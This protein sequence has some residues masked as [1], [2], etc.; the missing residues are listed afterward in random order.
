VDV[1]ILSLYFVYDRFNPSLTSLSHAY[2]DATE[3]QLVA[4]EMQT[5]HV[6]CKAELGWM[7]ER[8][9]V[10]TNA[11]ELERAVRDQAIQNHIRPWR[12]S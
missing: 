3:A 7:E 5:K 12:S 11:F 6:R 9:F 2:T 8:E 4:D 1:P 10:A